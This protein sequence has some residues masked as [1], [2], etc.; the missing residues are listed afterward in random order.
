MF[1]ILSPNMNKQVG[2]WFFN[3][4]Q[5]IAHFY[6][7]SLVKVTKAHLIWDLSLTEE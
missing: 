7:A 1:D 3:I 5:F 6:I 2:K 4:G